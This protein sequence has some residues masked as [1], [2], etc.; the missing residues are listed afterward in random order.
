MVCLPSQPPAGDRAASHRA[1]LA[2]R[3]RKV[4]AALIAL[5]LAQRGNGGVRLTP[6]G[7]LRFNTLPRARCSASGASMRRPLCRTP[8]RDGSEPK[9]RRTRKD[10]AAVP[11]CPAGCPASLLLEAQDGGDDAEELPAYQSIYFFFDCEHWMSRAEGNL[12]RMRRA[13][14]E[15]RRGRVRL[16]DARTRWIEGSRSLLK[17]SVPCGLARRRE[18]NGDVYRCRQV[19]SLAC[20]TRRRMRR[21]VGYALHILPRVRTVAI[22]VGSLRKLGMARRLASSVTRAARRSGLQDDPAGEPPPRTRSSAV[23]T[24]G[25]R[26]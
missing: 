23:K 5:A 25:H 3:R 7:R 19:L 11:R 22:E 17:A 24:R 20:V 14:I 16:C 21:L 1:R 4:A 13:M 18:L 15:H 26:T 9:S 10:P 12:T 2:R 6:H 8:D